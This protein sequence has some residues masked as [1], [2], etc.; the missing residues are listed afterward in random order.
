[1]NSHI[2]KGEYMNR[3]EKI[4][5]YNIVVLAVS[6]LAY[7]ILFLTSRADRSIE[8]RLY[9]SSVA[10][11]LWGLWG[12][13]H[14]IFGVKIR[15]GKPVLTEQEK[16]IDELA[17]FHGFAA[18]FLITFSL[19][20]GTFFWWINVRVSSFINIVALPVILMAGLGAFMFVMSVEVI[21]NRRS[22]KD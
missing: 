18:Y 1:M 15:G 22:A 19:T 3:L 12:I 14:L 16:S 4:A 10:F 2:G 21:K 5:W 11:G 20:L 17:R 8:W 7:I 13:G 6:I 9:V